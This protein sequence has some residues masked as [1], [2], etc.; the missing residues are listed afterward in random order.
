MANVRISELDAASAIT[1]VD[2]FV[3]MQDG[4]LKRVLTTVSLANF[5]SNSGLTAQEVA[6]FNS[7]VEISSG[8]VGFHGQTPTGQ[9]DPS[10]DIAS[11]NLP[12]LSGASPQAA[13]SFWNAS[14]RA[15]AVAKLNEV[16]AYLDGAIVVLQTFGLMAES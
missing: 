13:A 10:A 6:D 4:I 14:I 11:L 3:I 8:D 15:A 12:D 7:V 16:I 9:I 1:G 2:Q 5:F